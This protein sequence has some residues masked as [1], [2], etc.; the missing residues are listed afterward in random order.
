MR[1][2]WSYTQVKKVVTGSPSQTKLESQPT[3]VVMRSPQVTVM[4]SPAMPMMPSPVMQP[5]QRSPVVT[6]VSSPGAVLLNHRNSVPVAVLHASPRLSIVHASQTVS[7]TGALLH[8]RGTSPVVAVVMSPGLGLR[9]EE[10]VLP[11]PVVGLEEEANGKNGQLPPEDSDGEAF[12][13]DDPDR[14]Q[15]ANLVKSPCGTRWV[16]C[17]R[18]FSLDGSYGIW[19]ESAQ[20]VKKRGRS[21]EQYA[22]GLQCV[23]TFTTVQEFWR[24]WNA[25]DLQK[26]SNF[27]SL[28][29]FKYP[30]KPMWEDE[31]NK[32]GGS[33][34][35]KST[36]RPQAADFFTKLVLSLIGG[37]FEC[38]DALCGVVLVTKPKF[39]TL[40]LWNKK[41]NSAHFIPVDYEIRELCGVEN[42]EGVVVEY[43]EHGGA[44]LNNQAKRGTLPQE[45]SDEAK[46]QQNEASEASPPA[47]PA[48]TAV[49]AS[50]TEVKVL[51][52]VSHSAPAVQRIVAGTTT[53][54]VSQA[55]ISAAKASAAASV[56][57]QSSNAGA[58]TYAA[59]NGGSYA[60]YGSTAYAPGMA[61]YDAY[62]TGG[63]TYYYGFYDPQQY[64]LS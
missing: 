6:Y 28:S 58:S 12:D 40:Q 63:A 18:R 52:Q 59:Y 1:P 3:G 57:H 51:A 10:F 26:M 16:Q 50:K 36:S 35:L 7:A 5:Q 9:E 49:A 42:D 32:D 11:P 33:W 24:Y 37:Y 23:G 14:Q 29:V 13:V 56:A 39:N 20:N 53:Y 55:A 25:M 61:T 8:R 34:V 4:R 15:D 38:H 22:E 64:Q 43:K 60:A 2:A 47:D 62:A 31:H 44:I 46:P 48:G 27:C 54:K 21:E 41:V 17:S 19:F 30:I 45:A